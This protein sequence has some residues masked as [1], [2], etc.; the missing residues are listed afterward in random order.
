MKDRL[1]HA[2][3]RGALHAFGGVALSGAGGF[4]LSEGN[5]ALGLAVLGAASYLLI[6]GAVARGILLAGE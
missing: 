5:L 2:Q 1:K 3:P 6:A 4:V